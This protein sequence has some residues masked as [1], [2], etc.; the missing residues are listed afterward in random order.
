MCMPS[1]CRTKMLSS[2]AREVG[3]S[4]LRTQTNPDRLIS[5][6]IS[7][8]N[9]RTVYAALLTHCHRWLPLPF[10]QRCPDVLWQSHNIC[11]WTETAARLTFIVVSKMFA[12][13]PDSSVLLMLPC[14]LV[15][16]LCVNH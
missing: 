5:L 14:L 12:P 2:L 8:M 9:V 6:T 10:W 3:M 4:R 11:T 7:C 1:L 16:R 15:F 13:L